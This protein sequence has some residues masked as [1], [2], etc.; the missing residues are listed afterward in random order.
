MNEQPKNQ[1]FKDVFAADEQSAGS[2]SCTSK[3]RGRRSQGKWSVHEKE[4]HLLEKTGGEHSSNIA[5][6]VRI[7]RNND[8]NLTDFWLFEQLILKNM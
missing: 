6:I 3:V 7:E 2:A 5:I 4:N 8:T 1:L